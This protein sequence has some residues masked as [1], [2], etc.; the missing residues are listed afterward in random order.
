MTTRSGGRKKK[1][2]KDEDE[3]KKWPNM[4]CMYYVC[5]EILYFFA[6]H[7][8]PM[9]SSLVMYTHLFFR[10]IRVWAHLYLTAFNTEPKFCPLNLSLQ[11]TFSEASKLISAMWNAMGGDTKK[12]G[13]YYA[14][15]T[16]VYNMHRGISFPVLLCEAISREVRKAERGVPNTSRNSYSR[17][18]TYRPTSCTTDTG[19]GCP[20][21]RGTGHKAHSTGGND[22]RGGATCCNDWQP[23]AEAPWSCS[24]TPQTSGRLHTVNS[25]FFATK[26]LLWIV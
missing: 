1:D 7:H 18:C 26:N 12:V 9:V 14:A 20:P 4:W 10:Q 16:F 21:D 22:S 23:G 6:G 5:W 24:H 13:H 19:C 2:A 11:M 17:D 15:K 8:P 25:V 3:P